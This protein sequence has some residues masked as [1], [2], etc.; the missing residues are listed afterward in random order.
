M[1]VIGKHVYAIIVSVAK[2]NTLKLFS[3]F[4]LQLAGDPDYP[5]L[6]GHGDCDSPEC[7]HCSAERHIRRSQ[8]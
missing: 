6:H 2:D 5:R 1:M 3:F 8:E 7:T 4:L